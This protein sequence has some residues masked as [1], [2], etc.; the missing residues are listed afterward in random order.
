VHETLLDL[1]D[2]REIPFLLVEGALEERVKQV[3]FALAF[4]S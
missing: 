4:L 2:E 1:L 3:Q